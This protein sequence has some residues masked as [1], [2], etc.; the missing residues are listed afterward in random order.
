MPARTVAPHGEKVVRREEKTL[1]LE[2]QGIVI[3]DQVIQDAQSGKKTLVGVF[4]RIWASAF[5]TQHHRLFLYVKIL[6]ATPGEKVTATWRLLG[7][8]GPIQ[9][10][11]S[12]AIAFSPVGNADLVAEFEGLLFAE[13]GL[14][15][16]VLLLDEKEAGQARI[17]VDQPKTETAAVH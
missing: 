6:G 4:D 13:R 5:P 17:H 7:P 9:D 14:Y 15:R 3:C 8:K 11:P 1:P 10:F 16:F 12:G 2:I